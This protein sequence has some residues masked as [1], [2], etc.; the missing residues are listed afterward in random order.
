[1]STEEGRKATEAEDKAAQAEG[2]GTKA[3][4]QRWYGRALE[5]VDEEIAK[6]SAILGIKLLDP[7][8]AERVV[9][10]DDTVCARKNDEAFR[11]LRGLIGMHYNLALTNIEAVG[12]DE[13][14]EM[15]GDLRRRFSKRYGLGGQGPSGS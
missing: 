2:E 7:G 15:L 10:G 6:Y 1:M 8:V 9:R 3:D 14:A 4:G 5:A 12:A 11:K 13:L